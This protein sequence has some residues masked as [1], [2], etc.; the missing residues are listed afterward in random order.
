MEKPKRKR[1][2][3]D[4][5]DVSLLLHFSGRK[6]QN[7]SLSSDDD[8]EDQD[9]RTFQEKIKS[10][11]DTSKRQK[12]NKKNNSSDGESSD[13]DPSETTT[14]GKLRSDGVPVCVPPRLKECRL[15]EFTRL[16][17]LCGEKCDGTLFRQRRAATW[18]CHGR[19]AGGGR[20]IH[21]PRTYAPGD[22][23]RCPKCD[24]LWGCGECL[25]SQVAKANRADELA[26]DQKNPNVIPVK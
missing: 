11:S 6:D 21:T 16:S 8:D 23:L 19:N 3:S 25:E 13:D 12:I 22:C 26:E 10:K 7:K 18:S 9:L 20:M 14:E 24:R 4:V 1:T 17:F 5:S 15:L 2:A